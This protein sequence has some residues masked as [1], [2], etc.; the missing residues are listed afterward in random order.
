MTV[1]FFSGLGADERAF[2]K[3]IIPDPWKVVHIKWVEPQQKENLEN[4]SKR[5]ALQIDNSE[6]YSFVGLSFGGIV[7]V[8]LL[9][10][11]YPKRLILISSISNR[12]EFSVGYK[13]LKI[14]KLHKV[15][16]A[17]LFTTPFFITYW[18]FGIKN[19]EEKNLLKH[20]VKESSPQ[21][22]KWA[23][24]QII[25]WKNSVR[26]QNILH[27]HGTADRLFRIK[28]VNVDISIK[29]GGHF[30]VY[31]KAEMILPYLLQEL[32]KE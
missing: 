22:I 9:K 25:S 30:M 32:S 19:S 20:I 28:K 21:F 16:P 13:I 23:I 7:A 11:L 26:P 10:Y 3:I 24:N 29:D 31:S 15:V 4:Y 6:S 12:K 8:E 17:K 14:I 18:F 27:I 5:I 1:Y 2:E